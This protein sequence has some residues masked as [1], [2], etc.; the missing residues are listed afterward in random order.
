M[1]ARRGKSA[2]NGGTPTEK[3]TELAES[4]EPGAKGDRIY[5]DNSSSADLKLTCDDAVER[6]SRSA[7]GT[8]K[9]E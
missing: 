2:S 3:K 7:S 1:A 4:V 9:M 8:M 5:V 6:V